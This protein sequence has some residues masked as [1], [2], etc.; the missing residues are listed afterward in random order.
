[1]GYSDGK[2]RIDSICF[3]GAYFLVYRTKDIHR[4]I[5]LQ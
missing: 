3:Y 2:N 4:Q 5:V 1:M